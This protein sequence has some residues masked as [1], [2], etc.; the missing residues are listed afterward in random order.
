MTEYGTVMDFK[1][2]YF[3]YEREGTRR[4][5]FAQDVETVTVMDRN[6]F[7]EIMQKIICQAHT[8]QC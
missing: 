3:W 1:E 2:R 7:W 8:K 5:K 6:Q 4:R